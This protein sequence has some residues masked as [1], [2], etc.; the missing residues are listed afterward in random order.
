MDIIEEIEAILGYGDTCNHCLGRFFGKRSFGL[1]N[2]ERGR[3]LRITHEI[4]VN[5][6]HREPAPESCWICGGELSRIDAWAAKVAEAVQGIEFK[7]FLIGTRVPP[8]MAESEEM[9]WSDLSLR[10]PEPLKAEMN[11][12]VGKAVSELTG[13]EADFTRP[14]IVAILDLA[15]ET[16]E[17]Q[18]NPVFFAGR[19]LKYERGIPQTRWDCRAC[20]G[21][22]C[23]RCGFTGKQYA[24]S[25]EELIGRPVIEAFDARDAILHGAGREDIDA[26]MLGSGRPFVMEVEAPRKRSVDLVALEEEINRKAEGRVA[27][28]LTGWADRKMVQTLKSDKAYKKYRILVEIDGPVTPDEFRAA[29]DQLKGVTIRQR[30]PIRVSHRRADRVRERQ[31]IDIQCTGRIDGRYRVEVVGEAGLYIKELVSGD[32]G[33]TRPSLAQILGRTARVVSLDVVQVKTTNEYGE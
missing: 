32:G 14:D 16:V 12:E 3:A 30:T 19:Y 6:P 13:K 15:A 31:V 10:D 5:E 33:R 7:T 26:R 28:H 8:L 11:R 29:L 25:V 2:E 9:V 17:I 4:V 20:R 1:T 27:V 18:V 24:D 21:V 22:G 23:E